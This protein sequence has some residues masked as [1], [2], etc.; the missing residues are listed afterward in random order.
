MEKFCILQEVNTL[1]ILEDERMQAISGF[2]ERIQVGIGF[3]LKMPGHSGITARITQ[4]SVFSIMETGR[5]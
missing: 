4:L 1:T 3:L 5:I 2:A